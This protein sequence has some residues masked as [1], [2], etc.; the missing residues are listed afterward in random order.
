MINDIKL[1]SAMRNSLLNHQ[2]IKDLTATVEKRLATGK[3]VNDI[4][5]GPVEYFKAKGLYDKADSLLKRKDD[6][7]QAI[8]TLKATQHGI[9]AI[10]TLVK[11][12]KGLA[13]EAKT[14][15]G[16]QRTILQAQAQKLM[17]EITKIAEDSHHNGVN[18][19]VEDNTTTP[20]LL[21][22][23]NPGGTPV[24]MEVD[25]RFVYLSNRS[26]VEIYTQN[27]DGTLTNVSTIAGNDVQDSW[28]DGNFLY[29]AYT[30]YPAGVATSNVSVYD[31]ADDGT[32]VLVDQITPGPGETRRIYGDGDYI[33]QTG[34][35]S[36]I[37]V[38]DVDG[39]GQLSLVDTDD[40]GGSYNDIFSDGNFLYV[41]AQ[42]GGIHTYDIAEDGTL[43]HMSTNPGAADDETG[44]WGDGQ[45]I[46]S[47]SR[48]GGIRSHSVD[49]NGAL[50]AIDTDK[51]AGDYSS[52]RGD[53]DYVYATT[54][55][56]IE[57]YEVNNDGTLNY[58]NN[59]P[60][61]ANAGYLHPYEDLIYVTD[62]T[63][64]LTVYDSGKPIEFV[65]DFSDDTSLSI[66]GTDVR[67]EALGI[68]KSE[69]NFLSYQTVD[70]TIEKLDRALNKLKTTA[71][72]YAADFALLQTRLELTEDLVNTHEEAGDKLTLADLEEESANRLA[73]ET[74]E[75]LSLFSMTNSHQSIQN[76]IDILFGGR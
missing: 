48:T 61:T 74:R 32:A 71:A 14:A 52:V 26:N 56:G 23:D 36:G 3:K 42:A 39:N 50:T 9:V 16:E 67:Q 38:Y 70:F 58:L 65:V 63:D 1:T 57:V 37:Y 55:N 25:D 41:A 29:V 7:D 13:E 17:E 66:E 5:D 8:S 18:L 15:N 47:V 40:Q 49:A 30:T 69:I 12:A 45:Y 60:T 64:G 10:E 27:D 11:Q 6:I 62:S 75:Q 35:S 51:Q 28:S 24:R 2:Q 53:D 46:Y 73:L 33:Y 4:L 22:S 34:Y 20:T 44:I 68:P 72:S 59:I 43:T 54:T 21:D 31:V 76:L 19:L